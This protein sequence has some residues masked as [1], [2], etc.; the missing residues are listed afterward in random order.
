MTFKLYSSGRLVGEYETF[1]KAVDAKIRC[2]ELG[3]KK[4]RIQK[5]KYTTQ[6][7]QARAI[8]QRKESVQCSTCAHKQFVHKDSHAYCYFK[9]CRCGLFVGVEKPKSERER[10]INDAVFNAWRSSGVES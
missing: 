1:G 10:V 8:E 6:R 7:S 4:L 3:E 9:G 2:L 5:T